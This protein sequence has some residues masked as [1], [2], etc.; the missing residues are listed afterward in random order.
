MGFG[1]GGGAGV[2]V[3]RGGC[4]GQACCSGFFS[5]TSKAWVHEDFHCLLYSPA[6]YRLMRVRIPYSYP[7]LAWVIIDLA[8]CFIDSHTPN[9]Q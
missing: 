2:C 9:M 6:S 4:S 3:F 1:A 5:C 8:I 7:F